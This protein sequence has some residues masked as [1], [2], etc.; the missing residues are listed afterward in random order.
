MGWSLS[1]IDYVN[2]PGRGGTSGVG[3]F[4]SIDLYGQIQAHMIFRVRG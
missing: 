3:N 1:G 2:I 4:L